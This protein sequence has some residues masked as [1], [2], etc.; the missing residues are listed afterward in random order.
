MTCPGDVM[1]RCKTYP[2]R[3]YRQ[4]SKASGFGKATAK[5]TLPGINGE[6][7][8][9]IAAK[10]ATSIWKIAVGLADQAEK[11]HTG[12]AFGAEGAAH[13]GGSHDARRADA[14][15]GHT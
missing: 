9:F 11:F 2:Y 12:F 5:G 1:G 3:V 10:Q 15:R 6:T 8:G 13:D 7:A 4:F 14:T